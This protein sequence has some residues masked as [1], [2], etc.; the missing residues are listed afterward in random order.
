MILTHFGINNQTL[1]MV[2]QQELQVQA[3]T[4]LVKTR[5]ILSRCMEWYAVVYQKKI[6]IQLCH[7]ALDYI[8]TWVY[9]EHY[10]I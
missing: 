1:L 5:P 4:V 3:D 9:Q 2:V 7:L 10:G 6:K 8:I